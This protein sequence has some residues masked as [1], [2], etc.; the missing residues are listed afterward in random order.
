L[1]AEAEKKIDDQVEKLG[2]GVLQGKLSD[3]VFIGGV[4]WVF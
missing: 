4:R 2:N 3:S 1:G